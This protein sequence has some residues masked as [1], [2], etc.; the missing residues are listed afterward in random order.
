MP[1]FESTMQPRGL[2]KGDFPLTFQVSFTDM[3]AV[4]LIAYFDSKMFLLVCKET[5]LQTMH[6]YLSCGALE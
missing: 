6:V 1:H 3:P 5:L 2:S 4:T